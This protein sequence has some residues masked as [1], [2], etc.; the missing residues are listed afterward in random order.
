MFFE[1]Q[2]VKYFDLFSKS[3]SQNLKILVNKQLI[4]QDFYKIKKISQ[5]GKKWVG[6]ARKMGCF[7][8][9]LMEHLPMKTRIPWI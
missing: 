6:H 8:R 5:N 7:L 2:N 4:L 1:K 3:F 9:R